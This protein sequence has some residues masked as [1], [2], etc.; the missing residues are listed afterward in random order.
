[1]G[2]RIRGNTPGFEI[3]PSTCYCHIELNL[4]NTKISNLCHVIQ[5][6]STHSR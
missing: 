5:Q 3:L 2:V 6:S 1:M 4:G